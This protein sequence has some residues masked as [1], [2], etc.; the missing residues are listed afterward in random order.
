MSNRLVFIIYLGPVSLKD[1]EEFLIYYDIVTYWH[2]LGG[3]IRVISETGPR[4]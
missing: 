4:S 1:V 2:C 3:K